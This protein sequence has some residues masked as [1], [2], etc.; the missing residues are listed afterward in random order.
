MLNDISRIPE[1]YRSWCIARTQNTFADKSKLVQ[2]MAHC[3]QAT[4][5]YTSQWQPRS[6]S[7]YS[8]TRPHWVKPNQVTFAQADPQN[9]LILWARYNFTDIKKMYF[10][11][12]DTVEPYTH[13]T[14]VIAPERNKKDATT[15][16]LSRG[17]LSAICNHV[18]RSS[19]TI[20]NWRNEPW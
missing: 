10:I 14:R 3:L 15:L 4:G 9:R 6:I 18:F 20:N 7:P 8:V 5:Y 1:A 12:T 19:K 2:T 13:Q 11:H 16:V 17:V